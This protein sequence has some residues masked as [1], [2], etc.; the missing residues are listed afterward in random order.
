[1]FLAASAVVY[2]IALS[3][4]TNKAAVV[5]TGYTGGEKMGFLEDGAVISALSSK[6]G[7]SMDFR[8]M[9]SLDMARADVSGLDFIFPSSSLAAELYKIGGGSLERSADV[10]VSPLVIY[11]WDIVADALLDKGI[12]HTNPDGACMVDMLKL[13][14]L[15]K[16]GATWADIGVAE[17]YGQICVYSTDPVHSNS[18]NLYAALTATMLNGGN[19]VRKGD[20][21][22]IIGDLNDIL[23]KS[24]YKETSSADL[25]SQYLRT[26]AGGRAMAALYE[27][28]IIE[29]AAQSPGDWEKIKAKIR[30]LYPVP[31]VWSNHTYIAVSENGARFIDAMKD[32]EMQR[33]AWEAHGFRIN[34]ASGEN[35]TPMMEGMGIIG[36]LTRVMD[37]PDYAVMDEIMKNLEQ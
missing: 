4:M 15:M 27:N 5:I 21:P 31:T 35:L 33:L 16:N 36:A 32:A 13:T 34:V 12:A 22:N 9:G 24:G 7:I 30:V 23:S 19:T 10:F 14:E 6:Y 1:M 25:F 17:L 26:G 37:M 18:G 3:W 28:Q 11:S 8:K 29:F 20:V 2:A